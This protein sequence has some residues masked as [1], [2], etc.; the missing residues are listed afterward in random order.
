M[1][2]KKKIKNGMEQYLQNTLLPHAYKV[3]VKHG[4]IGDQDDFKMEVLK[5][6]KEEEE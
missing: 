5:S 6:M 4:F 2:L 1:S 3:A